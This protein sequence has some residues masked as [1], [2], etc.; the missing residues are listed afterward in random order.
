MKMR[1]SKPEAGNK[2][3]ITTAKGGYSQCIQGSPT[4]SGCNV[5]S[6]CVGYACGRFN[7]I[8]G[9]MKYPALNC[10][11]E[12]FIE[13]AQTLGL[14]VSQT[15]SAGAI[16]CWQKGSLSSSDGAGHVEVVERVDG[17]NQV[18]T[19]ASNYAGAAFY[20]ATR[21][22]NSQGQWTLPWPGYTFRGFI[23]N[24]A[25][26]EEPKETVGVPVQ[27]DATKDQIEILT[28]DLYGR[29]RP[30]LSKELIKGFVATGVYDLLEERAVDIGVPGTSNGYYW[31]GV[32]DA[33]GVNFWV[34]RG[35]KGSTEETTTW[36]KKY[37][38]N[39]D[40]ENDFEPFSV[41]IDIPNLNIR[42]GP[43]KEYE[44][45]G[46][47]GKGVFTIVNK[48]DGPG[49][50]KGWGELKSGAGWISLDYVTE[51]T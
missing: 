15:P 33:A 22:K 43:G 37:A 4:D 7:E 49:S 39:G 25:V 5:L 16:M 50:T 36:T 51:M 11:A 26:K 44:P 19:S 28:S 9:S 18:Y 30:E 27:R 42:K 29:S 3:Y 1:T 41:Q 20:N 40:D 47:T 17:P 10:N 34:A 8:I 38:K 35:P 45:T 6:N 21:T 13:R 46:L 14:E 2:F 31:Y 24:P 12:N 32:R 23:V 48:T